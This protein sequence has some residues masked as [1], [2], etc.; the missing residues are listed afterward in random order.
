MNESIYLRENAAVTAAISSGQYR[1]GLDEFL[2][3]GQ[4]VERRGVIFN[5][6]QGNDLV[7]SAGQK[8]SVIGVKVASATVGSRLINAEV[9]SFGFGEQDVLL[10]SPGRNVFYLG[11]NALEAP[12][13]FY[14][15]NGAADFATVRFFDPTSEDAIYLAG[16]PEDYEFGRCIIKR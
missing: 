11:D 4:F 12:R 13:D 10:G 1:S 7:F 9:E 15:G 6:T 8:S 14:L 2:Q 16:Q 3:E 5:G